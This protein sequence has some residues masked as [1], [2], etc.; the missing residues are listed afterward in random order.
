MSR[1]PPPF[2]NDSVIVVDHMLMLQ[3]ISP[4]LFTLMF[5]KVCLLIIQKHKQ[6]EVVVDFVVGA[7][8]VFPVQFADVKCCAIGKG[9]IYRY[10]YYYGV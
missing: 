2:K 5:F 4:F 8:I 3:F 6:L 10:L 1:P 7:V 9:R